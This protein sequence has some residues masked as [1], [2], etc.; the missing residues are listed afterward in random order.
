MYWILMGD[1][2]KSRNKES[3]KLVTTFNDLITH[4][5]KKFKPEILSPLTITLG[6][7]FQ[8]ILKSK[9]AGI[10]VIIEAEEWLLPKNETIE[11][12]YVLNYGQVDTEINKKIAHGMLGPGLTETR[13]LL[14]ELKHREE[15]YW[16][17]QKGEMD[18]K[19]TSLFVIMQGITIDWKNEKR[20]I[21]SLFLELND[22]KLVAK[23]LGKGISLLWKREKSLRI[24][25]YKL[26]KTLL[27]SDEV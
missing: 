10:R 13:Q 11:I 6:D 22:Y 18:I 1:I 8:G 17:G 5:N 26:L 23:A 19:T 21:A 16:V 7:E 2:I 15:R 25:E 20:R 12:R 3:K 24:K 14:D 4:L 9:N 27:I